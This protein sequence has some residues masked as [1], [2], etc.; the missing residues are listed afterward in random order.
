MLIMD[1]DVGEKIW[2]VIYTLFLMIDGLIYQISGWLYQLYIMIASARIFTTDTF[3]TFLTRIYAILGVVMLFVLAYSLLQNIVDPD[4]N[5]I[6]GSGK[7]IS[8]TIISI[9]L[10]AVIPTIFNFLYYAQEIIVKNNTIGKLILGSYSTASDSLTINFPDDLCDSIN[11]LATDGNNTS[12][13]KTY[14]AS[15]KSDSV[16][17]AGYSIATDVFSAFYYPFIMDSS[18]DSDNSSKSDLGLSTQLYTSQFDYEQLE[19]D[20]VKFDQEK[21]DYIFRMTQAYSICSDTEGVFSGE[22]VKDAE[23]YVYG[24]AAKKCADDVYVANKNLE[25]GNITYKGMLN[26]AKSEG[27]FESFKLVAPE[28]RTGNMS[29]KFI[30]SAIAGVF[31]CYIFVSY[32][33]DMGL[34]A[35]KLGFAQLIAPVPILSRIMPQDKETFSKWINFT[36]TS[37]YEVFLR[38]AVVFLGVFMI[39]NLPDIGS[40]WSQSSFAAI[41]VMNLKLPLILSIDT[42]WGIMSFAKAIIII[43]ILMFIKQAPTLINE[44]L[45][46]SIS[47]GSLNIRNKLKNMV[48]GEHLIKGASFAAGAATGAIGAGYMSKKNGGKFFSAA[49]KGGHDGAKAGGWQ[50]GKQG[51]QAYRDVTGDK[52]NGSFLPFG[53][54]SIGGIVNAKYDNMNKENRKFINEKQNK[55]ASEFEHTY[56]N[57]KNFQDAF[58]AKKST[59]ENAAAYNAINEDYKNAVYSAQGALQQ[60]KSQ[61]DQYKVNEAEAIKN[62]KEAFENSGKY[63]TYMAIARGAARAES[64]Y[65]NMTADEQQKVIMQKFKEAAAKDSASEV[66][67][68]LKDLDRDVN[69]EA[70]QMVKEATKQF[71]IAAKKAQDARESAVKDLDSK[72]EKEVFKDI[73]NNPH[74]A[75]EREYSNAKSGIKR[76]GDLENDKEIRRAFADFYN[77]KD[78][79]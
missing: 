41:S 2:N 38:L 6:G 49:L 67:A 68:Y 62:R 56:K 17:S 52:Y 70:D 43:G 35:A 10:I 47:T 27:S 34:R 46:I 63:N 61:A 45:G 76:R 7:I 21:N 58:A 29:Y 79:K 14:K 50:F 8:N 69:K 78:N 77:K 48:G 20:G 4:K 1:L 15:G 40:L 30:I 36:I 39:T 71:N 42:S 64:N 16:K 26:Y 24:E 60:A 9:I 11:E 74:G 23:G 37:Y 5:D 31:I 3:E 28:V 54:R 72:L 33:L 32:C 19:T 51:Q 55:I 22:Q 57:T 65:A 44:A 53:N 25:G 18:N 13:K 59:E 75:K 73:E 12:C 66:Q